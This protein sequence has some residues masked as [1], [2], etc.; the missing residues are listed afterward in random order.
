MN[1]SKEANGIECG[2]DAAKHFGFA[3]GYRNL[4]HGIENR[5][6]HPSTTADCD[7]V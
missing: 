7:S 6:S 5:D 2:G 1:G 4:N 3:S